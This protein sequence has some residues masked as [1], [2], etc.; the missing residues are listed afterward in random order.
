MFYPDD[1]VEKKP[2]LLCES[3]FGDFGSRLNPTSWSDL[4]L[5]THGTGNGR[6]VSLY[7]QVKRAAECSQCLSES[8]RRNVRLCCVFFAQRKTCL[9]NGEC[10]FFT[11]NCDLIQHTAHYIVLHRQRSVITT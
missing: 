8:E 4:S 7:I 9:Y 3:A 10:L 1:G 2:E 5:K 11:F 6:S